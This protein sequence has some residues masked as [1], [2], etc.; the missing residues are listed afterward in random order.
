MFHHR[1]WPHRT[2]VVH[3]RQV[4]A[5]SLIFCDSLTGL[6]HETSTTTAQH[7]YTHTHTHSRTSGIPTMKVHL[8]P[9]DPIADARPL[10]TP[11][12]ASSRRRPPCRREGQASF[13]WAHSSSKAPRSTPGVSGI[14]TSRLSEQGVPRVITTSSAPPLLPQNRLLHGRAKIQRHMAE[15]AI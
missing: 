12:A 13:L 5:S 14:R 9:V 8:W 6:T 7:T 10:S 2:V 3:T 15:C 1:A 11:T 4:K